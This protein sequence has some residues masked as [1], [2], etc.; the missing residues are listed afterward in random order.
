MIAG[1]LA[2][3]GFEMERQGGCLVRSGER[4]QEVLDPARPGEARHSWKR[5]MHQGEAFTK[6]K[7]PQVTA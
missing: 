5:V 3:E 4:D 6:S 1:A 2:L 7:R